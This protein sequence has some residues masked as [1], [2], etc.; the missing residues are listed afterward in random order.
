[1]AEAAPPSRARLVD[2][3]FPIRQDQPPRI[4]LV[5]EGQVVRRYDHGRPEPVKLEEEMKETLRERRVDI[6][7]RL[8]RQDE[9]GPS[10]EC[11]RDRD[12]LFLPTGQEGRPRVE[13]IAEAD[14]PQKLHD[15]APEARLVPPLHDEGQRDVFVGAQMVEQAKVLGTRSPFVASTP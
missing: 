7:R 2:H 4:H 6:A 8:V 12:P 11:A 15:L 14:P 10:D 3:E 5:H 9:L 1:M 13:L